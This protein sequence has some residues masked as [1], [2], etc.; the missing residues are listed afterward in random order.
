MYKLLII[1][2]DFSV[3]SQ[4]YDYG[5]SEEEKKLDLLGDEAK[6]DDSYEAKEADLDS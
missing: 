1:N 6:P 4:L 2:F 3:M 5:K